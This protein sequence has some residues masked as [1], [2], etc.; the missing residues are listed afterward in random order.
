MEFGLIDIKQTQM[1]NTLKDI[2]I[3][4][5]KK[6]RIDKILFNVTR[7]AILSNRLISFKKFFKYIFFSTSKWECSS[8]GNSEIP[9][10]ITYDYHRLDHNQYW[11]NFKSLFTKF[12]EIK[13]NE[14]SVSLKSLAKIFKS[15]K[16]YYNIKKQLGNDISNKDKRILACYLTDIY[17]LD[18]YINSKTIENNA[19]FIFFDGNRI[20]NL[21][22]QNLRNRGIKVAT[23][24]HGQPVF[25]GFD[26]DRINQ[27]MILNFSSDYI[28]VTGEYS[29][30]QFMLGDI[31]EDKIFVG[32][33]LRKM[34]AIKE[35]KGY[36]FA[37]FLDCPTNPNVVRDNKELIECA[38][39]LSEKL[40]SKY[41]VKCH[42]QDDPENYK[43][44]IINNGAF[45]SKS[46]SISDAL[47]NKA[48]AILHASGV[49]LD[50]ISNGTKAFCY[51]N[52]TNFPLVEDGLDS[53]ATTEELIEKNKMWNDY[54]SD[55]KCKYMESLIK[56]YL[57]PE[58]V[59]Q[60]YKKF[61]DELTKGNKNDGVK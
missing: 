14:G 44:Y 15:L 18:C 38:E 17:F 60:R 42:P 43:S 26:R 16:I 11:N 6:Y 7:E 23:M 51:V 36:D 55:K 30:K 27:T 46:G 57:Y 45:L 8:C 22:V 49:Y 32:G 21:V 56:Y 53:F 25:H 58:G 10:F 41:T 1:L 37:I 59:E 2:K 3:D 48:F 5:L 35:V 31:P 47:N 9:L 34:K 29:K 28:M 50:I 24:Q 54:S 39:A 4:C 40:H 20:E 13:I 52:D 19:A 61:V 33:S 12:D